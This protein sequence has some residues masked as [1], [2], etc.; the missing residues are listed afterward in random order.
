MAGN[1]RESEVGMKSANF[2]CHSGV[3]RG[4]SCKL[5]A[6]RR[7]WCCTR[8]RQRFPTPLP[9]TRGPVRR[10]QA[11]ADSSSSLCRLGPL[12]SSAGVDRSHHV[13]DASSFHRLALLHR[14][15]EKRRIGEHGPP[16]PFSPMRMAHLRAS[17]GNWFGTGTEP[18]DSTRLVHEDVCGISRAG[19]TTLTGS[20]RNRR[21]QAQANYAKAVKQYDWVMSE[22]AAELGRVRIGPRANRETE[23]QWW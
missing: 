15:V 9:P 13:G 2:A 3:L 8:S 20:M 5:R 12:P 1:P 19:E 18:T 16:R 21:T 23:Y 4:S 7:R 10:A 11:S 6:D 14:G 22:N 17:F